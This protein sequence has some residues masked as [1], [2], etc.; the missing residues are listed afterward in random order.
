[1]VPPPKCRGS[2]NEI[3]PHYR[4]FFSIIRVSSSQIT[5]TTFL[6]RWYHNVQDAIFCEAITSCISV[7]VCRTTVLPP[8]P[9]EPASL[10]SPP[11]ILLPQWNRTQCIPPELQGTRPKMYG[12]TGNSHGS[13]NSIYHKELRIYTI[14]STGID[15]T[16]SEISGHQFNFL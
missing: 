1:M 5:E 3:Y 10:V 8:S 15:C 16:E 11:W 2:D 4:S 7:K 9:T 14:K 6:N 13:G 12:V